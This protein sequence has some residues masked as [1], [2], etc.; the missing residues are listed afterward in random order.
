MM[1]S[2]MPIRPTLLDAMLADTFAVRDPFDSRN[3][4]PRLHATE[5]GYA[6]T[7]SAPGVAAADLKITAH[8]GTLR[9]DGETVAT[10]HTHVVHWS[11]S[12]PRDAD[13]AS[14]VCEY[15]D[16]VL[17][18]TIPKKAAA[19]ATTIE[20]KAEA[21]DAEMS[22][23]E[24]DDAAESYTLTLEA[25]GVAAADV[26]IKAT[27]GVLRVSGASRRTGGT[28][29]KCFRLPRDAEPADATAA[30]VDGLLTVRIP[31]RAEAEAKELT[32]NPA[33]GAKQ[34]DEAARAEDKDA[35]PAR[36]NEADASFEM[37]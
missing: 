5:D 22:D 25:P 33:Q 20:V 13:A 23:A 6:L 16:G 9:I 27:D 3:L 35:A 32:I 1:L 30:M 26:S 15:V 28:F 8:D 11:T 31:K 19:A 4:A 34:V 2:M 7:A 12:L 24:G 29:A 37:I 10:H 14:A 36:N 21:P 18:V 17:T